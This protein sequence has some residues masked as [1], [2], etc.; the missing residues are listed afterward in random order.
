MNCQEIK[1]QLGALLD[2]ALEPQLATA[3]ERHLTCCAECQVELERLCALK[4]AL[5][6][7][8]PPVPSASLDARVLAAFQQ[9]HQLPIRTTSGASSWRTW[10]FSRVNIPRPA[11]ALMGMLLAGALVVAYKA[12]EIRGTRLPAIEPPVLAPNQTAQPLESVR[13]V[14]VKVPGGCSQLNSQS[15]AVLAQT[16]V[17]KA[18]NTE[19]AALQFETQASASEAGIDY[20]TT[21]TPE[22]FEPVKDPGVRIIKADGTMRK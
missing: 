3:M 16:R 13:V 15:D 10:F 17:A 18:V 5:Q 6:S 12:G 19:S 8:E 2:Q 9:K 20:T 14:Y 7:V 1:A 21:A 11:L 4:P 22:S